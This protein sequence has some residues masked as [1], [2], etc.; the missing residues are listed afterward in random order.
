MEKELFLFPSAAPHLPE[1]DEWLSGNPPE[2]YAIARRWFA[3][4][5]NCGADVGELMHDGCPTA[6]VDGAAFGYVNVFKSHVN[7]GFFTGAFIDDPRSLLE[8]TGKR[9]RHIKLKPETEVDSAAVGELIKNAYVD[10]KARL[11][12]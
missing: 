5:R 3:V 11:H 6:C 7:L 12:R 8:G 9:M 2:L 1:I 4:F 10:V